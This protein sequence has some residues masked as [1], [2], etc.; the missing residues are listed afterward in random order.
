MTE[1]TPVPTAEVPPPP[2][3]PSEPDWREVAM[4]L[5]EQRDHLVMQGVNLDLDLKMARR[6]IGRLEAE[7]AALKARIAE[8]ETAA[9]PAP[10]E[11]APKKAA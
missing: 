5:S 8:L 1:P 3:A 7:N 4:S 6:A 10:V 11:Q 2:S 9:K